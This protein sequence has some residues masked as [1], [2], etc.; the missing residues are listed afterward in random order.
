MNRRE[1]VTRTLQ[2]GG[3]ALLSSAGVI[4]CRR[5]PADQ[6]PIRLPY[7]TKALNPHIS[8]RTLEFHFHEHHRRYAETTLRLSRGTKLAHLPLPDLIKATHGQPQ[9]QRLY[10]NAAQTYNHAF[11]W[12]SMSPTGGGTPSREVKRLIKRSFGSYAR[13]REQFAATA[14]DLFGSGWVWLVQDGQRL[15]IQPTANAHT[16]LIDGLRP[17]LVIDLWEHAYYL[18]YQHGRGRYVD[19]FLDHL[20]NW[21]FF[22]ANWGGV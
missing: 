8:R 12:Q 10:N 16:P 20:V 17:L 2:W 22:A 15:A 21:E 9:Y 1:F 3:L 4:S 7:A 14:R 5:P 11:Y 19:A 6:G 18:D 13:F